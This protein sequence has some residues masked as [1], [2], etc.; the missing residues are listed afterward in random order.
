M[1][2]SAHL[3]M[4]ERVVIISLAVAILCFLLL[5]VWPTL[6]DDPPSLFQTAY[7]TVGVILVMLCALFYFSGPS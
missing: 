2:A 6:E 3:S 4:L 7:V 5:I 1:V